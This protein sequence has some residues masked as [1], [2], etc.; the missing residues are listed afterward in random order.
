MTTGAR[1]PPIAPRSTRICSRIRAR[2][3]S[4]LRAH[5]AGETLLILESV[6][7]PA[8]FTKGLG[9]RILYTAPD[10]LQFAGT[11]AY[12]ATAGAD[13]LAGGDGPNQISG[14][15]GDDV[16]NGGGGNDTLN[17]G[18]ENDTLDGGAGADQLTGGTGDD[19]YH[20]DNAGDGVI[21]AAGQGSDRVLAGT[22]TRSPR[23]PDRDADHD[24]QS[25]HHRD[26]PHRQ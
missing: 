1:S 11:F 21:E 13:T 17:G 22:A 5:F 6:P 9:A 18:S 14:L 2:R 7:R 3:R 16:L 25:R 23:G 26:Q 15:G 20:V 8:T 4:T 10:Q 19:R 24:Q 12:P